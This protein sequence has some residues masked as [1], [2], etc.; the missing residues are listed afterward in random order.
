MDY[1]LLAELYKR[2]EDSS[3]RLKKTFIFSQFLKNCPKNDIADAIY[4]V[5]GRVFSASDKH[6]LGLSSKLMAK[7]I[8]NASGATKNEL[9]K[10]W[11]RTGD[12]GEVAFSLIKN[13]K[14]M[15]LHSEKLTVDKVVAIIKSLVEMGGS[16]VINKKI[17]ATSRLLTSATPLEA[18]Y[19]TR[20]I[21][22]DMRTGI[23]S[24][25]VRDS[26]VWAFLPKV[27]GVFYQCEKCGKINPNI[28][29]CIS[30]GNIILNKFKAIKTKNLKILKANKI[31]VLKNLK[32]Y[33]A[34]LP[35]DIKLARKIYDYFID[36]VQHAYDMTTDFGEIAK[37]IKEKGLDGLKSTELNSG[38]P[39]KV[40]LY[41][42]A[43]GFDDAFSTV[44]T[45]AIGERKY[46]GFR[47]QIHGFDN[48]VKLFTR[49]LDDV[50]KQFPDVVSAIKKYVRSKNF[51][52]DAEIVGLN[53]KTKR[54]EPFQKISKRIKRK[55]D[56]EKLI[57]ELPVKAVVFDA[58]LINGNNLLDMPL[59]ERFKKLKSIIKNKKY[60][61]ELIRQ[62]K[63][64][65]KK[66]MENF[67]KKSL[68]EGHEG[69]MIKNIKGIYKPGKRVGYGVKI[70]PVLEALDLVIVGAEWGE[71]KRARW[72]SS[73]TL[74]CRDQDNFKEIGKVGTGIKEKTEEGV[75]FSELTNSLKPII[76]QE[77]G[78]I[79]KVKPR[80][81]VEVHYEEIQ[82]SPSYSSGFALRFPRVIRLRTMEKGLSDV[83][84]LEQVKK[85]YQQQK[86]K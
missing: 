49:R 15:T 37:N 33:D 4:L 86:G 3:S 12:L 65:N 66:K 39:I 53:P 59:E 63:T 16:G 76:I 62:L 30:C 75:S 19:I 27:L 7:A 81:I 72:L 60:I 23:G 64:S 43:K 80:I 74:A 79:V 77:T 78:R 50:T 73:F 61:I 34:I 14:Q 55:Y 85:L 41:Q 70:K 67:Y 8:I 20:T 1:C 84:S 25:T 31:E 32:K 36:K 83:S 52:I 28:N 48:K 40:M 44:G 13:K 82:K 38:N 54:I 10:E 51:I 68:A 17:S 45:P 47:M 9:N 71:G 18:K 21:L 22:E 69:I 35:N 26:L 5:Q 56:I 42:K 57:K 2:L 11:K 24:S 29:K 6:I 58:M 46:D